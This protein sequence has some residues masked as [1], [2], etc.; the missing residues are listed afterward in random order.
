VAKPPAEKSS[1]ANKKSTAVPK[2]TTLAQLTGKRG[3]LKRRRQLQQLID[4][5]QQQTDNDLFS[6]TPFRSTKLLTVSVFSLFHFSVLCA[7]SL[8]ASSYPSFSFLA[9][10]SKKLAVYC[11]VKA[12]LSCIIFAVFGE[13][14][15]CI[16][17]VRCFFSPP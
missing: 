13:D 9:H 8:L 11:T 4:H 15:L 7:V 17:V 12:Q 10:V 1:K 14:D 2:V 5:F 3:T 16:L 6:S